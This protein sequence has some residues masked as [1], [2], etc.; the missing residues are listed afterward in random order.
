MKNINVPH[1]MRPAP[2]ETYKFTMRGFM[3]NFTRNIITS[4][5]YIQGWRDP[6]RFISIGDKVRNR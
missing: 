6:R 3:W 4:A 1:L 5:V 2:L